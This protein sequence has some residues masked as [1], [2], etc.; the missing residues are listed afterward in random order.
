MTYFK[1]RS[2]YWC[3]YTEENCRNVT[4]GGVSVAVVTQNE[5]LAIKS[6]GVYRCISLIL[7]IIVIVINILNRTLSL[8][9]YNQILLE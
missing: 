4:L 3:E 7:L 2:R 6:L 1:A 9:T 8:T 5:Y